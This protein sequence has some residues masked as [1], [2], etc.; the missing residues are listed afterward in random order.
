MLSV[1]PKAN[2][3]HDVAKMCRIFELSLPRGPVAE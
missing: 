2:N 1:V 3:A